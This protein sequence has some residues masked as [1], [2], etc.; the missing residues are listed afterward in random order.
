MY[1]S[2]VINRNTN[3]FFLD[4]VWWWSFLSVPLILYFIGRK[5]IIL[6][7]RLSPLL[8]PGDSSASSKIIWWRKNRKYLMKSNTKDVQVHTVDDVNVIIL[9]S[10]QLDWMNL[11]FYQRFSNKLAFSFVTQPNIQLRSNSLHIKYRAPSTVRTYFI[12]INQNDQWI[13]KNTKIR[14]HK[15]IC[16]HRHCRYVVVLPFYEMRLEWARYLLEKFTI[17][18]LWR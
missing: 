3:N 7:F 1:L 17:A 5:K 15:I 14:S 2:I 6:N 11:F 4:I 12:D 13:G 10:R 16:C 9:R 18:A 8:S